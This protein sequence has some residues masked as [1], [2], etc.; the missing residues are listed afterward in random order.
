M[1][2]PARSAP[3]TF[4]REIDRNRRRSW[5]LVAAVVLVLGVLGGAIGYA[6]STQLRRRLR[7]ISR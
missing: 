1:T 4:Y 3:T 6:T 5:V 2:A 7:S